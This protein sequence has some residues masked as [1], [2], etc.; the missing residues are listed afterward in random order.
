ML[1][2]NDEQ[3]DIFANEVLNVPPTATTLSSIPGVVFNAMHCLCPRSTPDAE[4]P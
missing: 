1:P 4:L 3:P 2:M